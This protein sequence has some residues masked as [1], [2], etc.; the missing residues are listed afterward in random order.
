MA[1]CVLFVL[2]A[3]LGVGLQQNALFKPVNLEKKREKNT[4]TCLIVGF[5]RFVSLVR[6]ARL[7]RLN[8]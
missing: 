8:C 4:I 1:I 5:V 3:D 7:V 6:F 2:H